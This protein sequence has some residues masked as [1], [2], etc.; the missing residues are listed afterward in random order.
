MK[1]EKLINEAELRNL[2]RRRL[3]KNELS[4]L[5]EQSGPTDLATLIASL[6]SISAPAGS[7][8]QLMTQANINILKAASDFL[9]TYTTNP[10]LASSGVGV[11]IT[12]MTG[13]PTLGIA[14][15]GGIASQVTAIRTWVNSKLIQA[16][17]QAQDQSAANNS[18]ALRQPGYYKL[19]QE[20]DNDIKSKDL[21]IPGIK[22]DS[23]GETSFI[24]DSSGAI[25][26]GFLGISF[27]DFDMDVTQP[28]SDVDKLARNL[29]GHFASPPDNVADAVSELTTNSF[30]DASIGL[31]DHEYINKFLF[32]KRTLYK[33]MA[34][35]GTRPHNPDSYFISRTDFNDQCDPSEDASETSGLS[36]AY[37]LTAVMSDDGSFQTDPIFPDFTVDLDANSD[38]NSLI[39]IIRNKETKKAFKISTSLP[40]YANAKASALLYDPNGDYH[41]EELGYLFFGPKFLE[42]SA[43]GVLSQKVNDGAD[44]L[45]QLAKDGANFLVTNYP[46]FLKDEDGEIQAALDELSAALTGNAGVVELTALVLKTMCIIIKKGGEAVFDTFAAIFGGNTDPDD[47]L[48]DILGGDDPGSGRQSATSGVST[49]SVK[50]NVITIQKLMNRYY[51][52]NNLSSPKNPVPITGTWRRVDD[53]MDF[54]WDAILNHASDNNAWYSATQASDFD[55]DGWPVTAEY[56]RDNDNQPFTGDTVGCIAFLEKLLEST[57]EVDQETSLDGEGSERLEA[58]ATDTISSGGSG[59]QPLDFPRGADLRVTNV[60]GATYLED[61]GFP[62]GSTGSLMTQILTARDRNYTG[63]GE[64]LNFRIKLNDRSNSIIVRRVGK[65]SGEKRRDRRGVEGFLKIIKDFF[66]VPRNR[67]NFNNELLRTTEASSNIYEFEI[68][69]KVPSGS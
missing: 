66:K 19:A 22:A 69:I 5:N 45:L 39:G 31:L 2:I 41:V 15:A 8:A 14:A 9:A 54:M 56:L 38:F 51:K 68:G 58:P 46:D 26:D 13:S 67:P 18:Y 49:G 30:E 23:S 1:V 10:Y 35:E 25:I 33:P 52:E 29:G 6:A 44:A 37:V 62:D 64:Y 47:E 42:K 4:I 20:I 12:F 48:E 65:S 21:S 60:N 34:G 53:H 43:L 57:G 32:S 27:A 17:Q 24:T 55:N 7:T 16:V 28:S 11:L 61:L 59:T 40:G 50:D 36:V 3:L 63:S